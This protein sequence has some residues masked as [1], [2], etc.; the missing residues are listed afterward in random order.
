MSFVARPPEADLDPTPEVEPPVAND[1]FFPAIDPATIRAE[2]RVPSSI[3]SARLRAAIIAAIMTARI[4]LLRFAADALL[5]GHETLIAMPAPQIDGQSLHVLT[6]GRAIGLLAKAELIER[7]R[8]FDSTAT[9]ANQALELEGS[10]GELRRDA[11]HA[12]RDLQ[13]RSRTTVDLI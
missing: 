9:G 13:G 3:T 2:Q 4:D 8:D 11:Q 6:Y 1:G 5:A 12:L 7:H 10:I